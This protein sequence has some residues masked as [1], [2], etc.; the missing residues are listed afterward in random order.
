MILGDSTCD[1]YAALGVFL[2]DFSQI[3]EYFSHFS[4]AKK[5]IK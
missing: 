1:S 5:Y 3:Y 4:L 2:L